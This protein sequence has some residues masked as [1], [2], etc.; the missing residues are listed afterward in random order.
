MERLYALKI[1]GPLL[2]SQRQLLWKLL[3]AACRKT[4]FLFQD[5][6][7]RG[8]MEGL[9]AMLEEIAD[10]A[11]DRYGID[12][13]LEATTEVV[14]VTSDDDRCDCAQPGYFCSG[15]PGILAHAENG[16]VSPDTAVQRCD[17]CERYP[18][19][20]AART[21]LRDLDMLDS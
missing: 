12:C 15:V 14:E 16:R 20:E 13:L 18:S 11:H 17:L 21:K 7:N 6:R 4:P 8:L 5:D 3:D 10:Q 1:D 19:D 9:V 2:R